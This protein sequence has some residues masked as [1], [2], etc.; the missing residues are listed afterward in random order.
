M[1]MRRTFPA[2]A[3]ALTLIAIASASVT[4][5]DKPLEGDLKSLQGKWTAKAGPD[6][7]PVFLTFDKS[8]IE[9]EITAPTGEKKTISGSFTIDEKTTPKSMNWADMKLG[10]NDVPGTQAIYAFDGA[11]TLKIAGGGKDR[12]TEFVEKGKALPGNRANTMVFTRVKDEP[13]K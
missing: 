3:F 10:P 7:T 9:F 12:P 13:K 6:S 2:L 1:T 4:A 8:K 5:D 11:D